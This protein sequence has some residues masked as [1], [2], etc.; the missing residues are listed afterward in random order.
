MMG[1]ELIMKHDGL[2]VECKAISEVM[3]R[4]VDIP[5]SPSALIILQAAQACGADLA[6]A[7]FVE[8]FLAAATKEHEP[9]ECSI[10][11]RTVLARL[12]S[13]L[14][15]EF[16]GIKRLAGN[17]IEEIRSASPNAPAVAESV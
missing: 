12:I 1:D 4:L 14:L 17:M 3:D 13:N 15:C 9:I 16:P 5:H 6:A 11:H 2:A 10:G 7:L 8:T